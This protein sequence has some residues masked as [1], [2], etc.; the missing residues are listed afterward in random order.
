MKITVTL[1]TVQLSGSLAMLAAIRRASSLLSSLAAR[2]LILRRSTAAGSGA[3]ALRFDVAGTT[4]GVLNVPKK[5]VKHVLVLGD[6]SGD[7]LH[8]DLGISSVV[9]LVQFA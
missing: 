5:L 3:I 7:G 9:D 4:E 1:V 8:F 6:V 2:R